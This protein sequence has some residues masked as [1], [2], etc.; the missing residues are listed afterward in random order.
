MS[1]EPRIP[2]SGGNGHPGHGSGPGI[3]PGA[4][5]FAFYSLAVLMTGAASLLF[6]DLLW[7]LGWSPSRTVLLVLFSILFLLASVGCIHGVY[8]FVLRRLGGGRGIT[9]LADYRDR[10]IDETSTALVFPIY[11]EDV[12]RVCAGLRATFES[13]A[14]TGHLAQFDFF[15]LSDS[16]NPDKWIQEEQHWF[17]LTRD[18]GALGRIFYRRRPNNEGKKSGNIRDFLSMWGRRYRYFIVF[19]ADSI[20]SG[21]TLVDLVKLMETHPAAGLIQ[22]APG[23][24]NARTAF[25]RIQQFGQRLYS[26]I[27]N[28]GFN[29]WTQDGG[30]Y[31]GHNAII[32]TEAFMQ[33]CD[34]PQ[35]PG[36]KPFGGHILS[37]DFVEA[38]LMRRENWE[39]WFAWDLDGSY[40]EGPPTIIDNAQRDRRWCQ[41]NLQHAMLLF[42]RG[43]RGISRLHLTF[44][45]FCYLG[46]P[47]WLAFMLT[48]S[49]I[50]WYQKQTGLSNVVVA[51]FTP[52]IHFGA[53]GHAL[54]VFGIAMTVILLPKLL[55]LID[56]ALDRER[57]RAFGGFWRAAAGAVL[58]TLFSALH[59][60]IQM[61]FQTGAVAATL[62]GFDTQ[63]TSQKRTADGMTWGAAMR[64]HW[65]HAL[66]GISWGAFTWWLDPL[67]F[68]WFIPV[69]AGMV[70]SIPI[71]VL[72]SREWLGQ[73]FRRAGLFLTPEEISPPHELLPMSVQPSA[74]KR[75]GLPPMFDAE[76]GL[77][78]AILDPYVNALHVSLLR[79]TYLNPG[80][81]PPR[82]ARDLGEK[83]LAQGPDALTAAERMAVL[84]DPE[85]ASWLHRE[86]WLRPT[87]QLGEWWRAAIFQSD[88]SPA[89]IAG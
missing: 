32:R 2:F 57:R 81:E 84:S 67:S 18:L 20:M 55:A 42:A 15:I 61:L 47:L 63:W 11:N 30:N 65:G 26:P 54:L 51:A 5:V 19:D 38:A 43:L 56:L 29:Y 73:A 13:V 34:L 78:Q 14:R 83:L 22:S 66:L 6:A 71:T 41:G 16:T 8:G 58:E 27:F 36:K 80:Y 88:E 40:E 74:R 85:T 4:R 1:A 23:L 39:V 50:L 75:L 17:A 49:Y 28:A 44:G 62:F 7:R 68:W 70:F 31:W 52:F 35:L 53:A 3:L 9:N 46:G 33:C 82:P 79:E 10:G 24:V 77:C 64:C 76:N 48:G 21:A 69:L 37:H 60:P 45:I 89:E 25:A 87:G 59:A 86:A 12:P 72:T